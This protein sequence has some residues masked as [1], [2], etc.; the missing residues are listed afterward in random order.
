MPVKSNELLSIDFKESAVSLHF[1]D[2]FFLYYYLFFI[3]TA[4]A[5]YTGGL[6]YSCFSECCL[7][8]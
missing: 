8:R 7:M 1:F 6:N 2:L 3:V 4:F 5:C